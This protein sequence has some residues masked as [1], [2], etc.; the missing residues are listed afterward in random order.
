MKIFFDT[1]VLVAA[2]ATHGSCNELLNH[3]V[4]R[5]QIFLSDFVLQELEEKLIKKIKLT[6]QET[7]QILTYL[8]RYCEV[9]TER[10]IKG[11]VSRDPDD[12]HILAAALNAEV[13][14]IVTGDKDLLVLK[15][16][17]KIP[18]V[19]PADFW[20]FEGVVG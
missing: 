8:K 4:A 5:H 13:Q 7:N 15:N 14:C 1:N 17:E 2:Y 3:C 12:D 20:K 6:A 10:K 11:K 9:T 18:I 16:F 19:K